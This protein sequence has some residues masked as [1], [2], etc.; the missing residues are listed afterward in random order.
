MLIELIP[1]MTKRDYSEDAARL[2]MDMAYKALA[3]S[4][5]ETA[6]NHFRHILERLT[7]APHADNRKNTLLVTATLEL[8]NLNFILGKGFKEAVPFLKASLEAA[9]QLGDRRSRAMIKLHLARLYYFSNQRQKAIPAFEEGRAEV[10]F[11]GDDDIMAQASEFIGLYYHIQGQ[12]RQA[13]EY[14]EIAVEKFESTKGISTTNPLAPMWLGYCAAYLGQFHRSVGMLDY[15]RRVSAE[16]G[17]LALA[18][19]TRA[20][21]GI[22]LLQIGRT[23]EAATHLFD[24]IK[25][26]QKIQ[27]A[28][29]VYFARGGIAYYYFLQGDIKACKKYLDLTLKDGE[30]AGLVRQYTSPEFLEMGFALY[31]A[32]F[33]LYSDGDLQNESIRI[34]SENN[35]HLRGVML[36]LA[37]VRRFESGGNAEDLKRDLQLSADWLQTAGTPVQ[38]ARTR[39]ELIRIHLKTG[40]TEQARQLAQKAWRDLA[41][42]GE[43]FYPDDLRPLL[44]PTQDPAVDETTE[45]VFFTRFISIVQDIMPAPDPEALLTRLVKS[46]N[47]YFGAERGALFWFDNKNLKKAPVLRAASNITDEEVF[48]ERFRSNLALVFEAFRNNRLQMIRGGQTNRGEFKN[49]AVLCL[50]FEIEGEIRGVLYHDNSYLSDC[51]NFLSETQLSRLIPA[52]GNYIEHACGLS[53]GIEALTDRPLI[54]SEQSTRTEI[55]GNSTGLNNVLAQIDR[56]AVTDSTVLVLGETGVGKELIAG[57]IHDKSPRSDRPLVIID[58]TSIPENL[59]E[60]ELFGHEKGAFTGADR[61]K[62]GLMELA[63]KGTLFIDEIGEIPLSAQVKLLRAIQEKTFMRVGGTQTISSDFRLVVATNRDLVEEVAAGRFREDLYYRL[64][65]I[66][67]LIPSLRERKKDILHL[68]RYFIKR[69]AV[70]YNRPEFELDEEQQGAL[71]AYA[72]PGNIRELKNIIERGVLLSTDDR[73]GLDLPLSPTPP[74]TT[75]NPFTDMP[76]LDEVQGRYISH[77]LRE[78]KGRIGGP[79]GAAAIL[80]I[81]RTT[82]YHRMKKLGIR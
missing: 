44:P 58:P 54:A 26:A 63:H 43:Q 59:V 78:T 81:N 7:A 12:F 65:V 9:E 31:K 22:V 29:A 32:G 4:D 64:N 21:L 36:R 49:K 1:A 39:F 48:A 72:W 2:E 34:M 15:Y 18:A 82:L 5:R 16:R 51:F 13:L 69:Y 30:K 17:D 33:S 56:I 25:Y 75:E 50:P 23:E 80:G 40:A 38:L 57:R 47:R 68:A 60:S 74:S 10:E 20:A 28:L 24:V 19:T 6:R 67:I 45:E 76:T 8:S 70:R 3:N 42:Y 62:K 71:L 11:L 52:L 61:Q 55:V 41:G 66:P 53:R 79:D 77:V 27:N 35:L 14:F 73:L 46:T 37:A